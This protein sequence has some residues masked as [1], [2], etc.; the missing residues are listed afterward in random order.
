ML[1]N[2]SVGRFQ[3]PVDATVA[4]ILESVRTL[5]RVLGDALSPEFN[6]YPLSQQ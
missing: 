5:H 2:P 6:S 1:V 3:H 4:Q